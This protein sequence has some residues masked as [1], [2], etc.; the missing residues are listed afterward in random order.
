[1]MLPLVASVYILTGGSL[2]ALLVG[3]EDHTH[4]LAGPFRPAPAFTLVV[5]TI[6]LWPMLLALAVGGRPR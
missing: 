2:A 6:L 4:P 3:G 5:G 1:M